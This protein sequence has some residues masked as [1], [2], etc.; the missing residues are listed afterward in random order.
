[1]ATIQDMIDETEESLRN[2]P[3]NIVFARQSAVD[4][5]EPLSELFA[6]LSSALSQTANGGSLSIKDLATNLAEQ[7]A[8][9]R[10]AEFGDVLK[11]ALPAPGDLT[12]STFT[13][14]TPNSFVFVAY[15][16]EMTGEFALSN[17]NIL[18]HYIVQDRVTND[19][20]SIDDS[21]VPYLSPNA[22][23]PFLPVNIVN[24][25]AVT[26]DA[27]DPTKETDT[28]FD[29]V[30]TDNKIFAFTEYVPEL[31]T[32]VEFVS[33]NGT[34]VSGEILIGTANGETSTATIRDFLKEDTSRKTATLNISDLTAVEF[35]AALLVT[36]QSSGA[37]GIVGTKT[38]N[39]AWIQTGTANTAV[40]PA[41][42]EL[43]SGQNYWLKDFNF[44]VPESIN[45]TNLEFPVMTLPA[46]ANINS[47]PKIFKTFPI[48]QFS[49][50]EIIANMIVNTEGLKMNLPP[51]FNVFGTDIT[52]PIENSVVLGSQEFRDIFQYAGKQD[53]SDDI[54]KSAN[55]QNISSGQETSAE[56]YILVNT[57]PFFPAVGD[58]S[59]DDANQPSR[60]SDIQNNLYAGDFQLTESENTPNTARYKIYSTQRWNLQVNPLAGTGEN[61]TAA[62]PGNFPNS[63]TS[64]LPDIIASKDEIE[65][66]NTEP[67]IFT[68]GYT[69]GLGIS[70]NATRLLLAPDIGILTNIYN[71]IQR[72]LLNSRSQLFINFV[73]NLSIHGNTNDTIV[74][75]DANIA[76][77]GISDNDFNDVIPT[78]RSVSDFV[79]IHNYW[80]HHQFEEGRIPQSGLG[81]E[82]FD[83]DEDLPI[84]TPL[85]RGGFEYNISSNNIY[86]IS[87][88]SIARAY[89]AY[90]G[91]LSDIFDLFDN[92][93]TAGDPT[94]IDKRI[95]ELNT[96]L[97]SIQLGTGY[98]SK[99]YDSVNPMLKGYVGYIQ[100]IIDDLGNIEVL[101]NE[102]TN[103]RNKRT[104][105]LQARG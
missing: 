100:N 87:N 4:N 21:P 60:L 95:D 49:D 59:A 80:L 63:F 93:G 5:A 76:I 83:Y 36:G 9:L 90:T 53:N 102:I 24:D 75:G 33:V 105:L 57:N 45:S 22:G 39:G 37:T 91:M 101:Y 98:V 85:F 12:T 34:F 7:R 66:A 69:N 68:E 32:R 17:M 48:K 8:I 46:S 62:R 82:E 27:P 19:L 15:N 3:Q 41:V 47:A 25:Q 103:L 84:E 65:S 26:G 50:N 16:L 20:V 61:D 74:T 43:V 31:F 55:S 72:E 51:V 79:D 13:F 86:I 96:R 44:I 18:E 6:N 64:R 78:E 29:F 92:G 11:F 94:A 1:M 97:G 54:L 30:L 38:A 89:T 56:N 77:G 23:T 99:I 81:S 104:A 14:P 71:T 88:T 42:R 28:R 10:G 67:V 35:P 73:D 70:N 52:D 2:A 40:T 58:P